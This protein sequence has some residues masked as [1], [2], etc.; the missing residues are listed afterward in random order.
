MAGTKRK[1]HHKSR[2]GC[3]NCKARKVKCDENKPSCSN[4]VRRQVECDFSPMGTPQPPPV[5]P[6]GLNMT[7]LELLHHYTTAT[8]RTLVESPTVREFYRKTV[9]QVGLSCDYIMRA[10]L[11]VSSL[12]LAHHRPQGRDHYQA[13]AIAHHQA[14]S[15]AAMPLI[16]DAT[17][18]NAQMLFLFSVLTTYY[19]LGWPRKPG[20]VLPRANSGFPD[21]VYLVRGTKGFIDLAGVPSEG[22]LAPLFAHSI[23]RFMLREG[24][25]A[26]DSSAHPALAHL[27]E[28]FA[29][30]PLEPGLRQIY[31]TAL[32]ELKKSFGQAQAC[33]PQYEMT[34]AFTWLFLIAEDLLP[35]L[36]TPT[37]EAVAI[38]AFFCV[39]LKKLEG[40]WWMQDWGRHLIAHAYGLL[41]EEGR[42]L[43]RWA[44]E[45][46]GWVPPSAMER[47]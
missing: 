39:L 8:Y 11:A 37:Q 35:L 24:P 7:D 5:S 22:P 44:V 32:Q 40:H 45:E 18:E 29:Q 41:D 16:S 6:G 34:D 4:C 42:L 30:R 36:R 12:H 20:D 31:G 10:I 38:F 13:V 21:W 28:A 1:A 19:S 15:Q 46:T 33:A 47:F 14:A 43:V 23:S 2:L 3:K 26:A 25:E 27:A 17:P 9:V